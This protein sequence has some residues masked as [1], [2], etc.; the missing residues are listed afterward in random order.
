MVFIYT[1]VLVGHV[2]VRPFSERHHFPHD[3]AVAPHIAGRGELPVSDGLRRRP[4]HWNLAAL[5]EAEKDK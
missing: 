5:R 1:Y 3:N 4:P 2:P